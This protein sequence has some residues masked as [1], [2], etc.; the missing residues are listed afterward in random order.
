MSIF[1]G[2]K[3]LDLAIKYSDEMHKCTT[4]DE[5]EK[6]AKKVKVSIEKLK[7]YIEWLRCEYMSVRDGLLMPKKPIEEMLNKAGLKALK[8]GLI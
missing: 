1:N 7:E 4:I 5:L 2:E 6:I 3:S 8:K